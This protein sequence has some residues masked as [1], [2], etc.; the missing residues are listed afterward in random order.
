MVTVLLRRLL[1]LSMVVIG[2]VGTGTLLPAQAAK[3]VRAAVEITAVQTAAESGNGFELTVVGT[4]RDSNHV[5]VTIGED[6][7]VYESYAYKGDWAAGLNPQPAGTLPICA[8]VR[9][10]AGAVLT[11]DCVDYTRPVDPVY[12]QVISPAQDEEVSST[13]TTVVG[14]HSGST[15]R[16]TMDGVSEVLPCDDYSVSRRYVDLVEGSHT[17]TVEM[18]A[19]DGTT[20]VASETRTFTSAP[21]PV[22]TVDITSPADG[23]TGSSTELTVTGTASSN[24]SQGVQ[25]Y[26]DGAFADHVTAVDGT[27]TSS[28]TVP[29]GTSRICAQMTDWLGNPLTTDC[30]T[31]TVAIEPAS[32]TVDTPSEGARTSTSVDVAGQCYAGSRVTL[33]LAGQSAD[34][35]CSAGT[36]AHTFD[37]VAGGEQTLTATMT[38]DGA[39]ISTR[40]TTFVVDVVAPAAPVVTS[41]TPGTTI[42]TRQV[43]LAGTA[44]PGSTVYVFEGDGDQY[45][46]TP[47]GAD[48]TFTVVLGEGYLLGA[49]VLN[50]KRGTLS[51]PLFAED[52]FGN[53]S[54]TATYTF[55]TRIR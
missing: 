22:A 43:T 54:A 47:V 40:S 38:Y 51:V 27:W 17:L 21:I 6:P 23:A 50:G 20:V 53:R 10:A 4:V 32:L 1:V 15:V 26:V 28:I 9:D 19:L 3:P 8:E 14:C 11:R 46:S 16:I 37:G 42:T 30:I 33:Q 45:A 55:A 12:F 39:E 7:N 49:G 34:V 31:Y 13:F 18:L 2:V 44:E 24:V 35:S 25:V 48:G 5:Y 52:E 41:P 36:Y 29:L